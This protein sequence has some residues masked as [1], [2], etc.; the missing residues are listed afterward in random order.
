MYEKKTFQR[1]YGHIP[2]NAGGPFRDDV[3]GLNRAPGAARWKGVGPAC[4]NSLPFKERTYKLYI[5]QYGFTYRA[6]NIYLFQ[7][8]LALLHQKDLIFFLVELACYKI[9]W[10]WRT[11][12]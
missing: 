2:C 12:M 10:T 7:T 9:P 6:Y 11:R 5:T 8:L 1:L 3:D 4:Q